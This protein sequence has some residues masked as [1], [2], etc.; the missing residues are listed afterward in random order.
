MMAAT[1]ASSDR[2]EM[3]FAGLDPSY[4]LEHLAIAGGII[5]A[6]RDIPAS[7]RQRDDVANRIEDERCLLVGGTWAGITDDRDGVASGVQP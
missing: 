1:T 5:G 4:G 3:G 7:V 2:E 6:G